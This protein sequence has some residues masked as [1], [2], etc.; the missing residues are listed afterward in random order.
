[1]TLRVG[2]LGAGAISDDHCR[3]VNAHPD[4]RIVAVADCSRK[5]RERIQSAYQ[6]DKG[7]A[8]WENLVADPDLDAVIVALPNYLHA[9]AAIRAFQKGKHVL[10]EKPFAMNW[11]EAKRI[12]AAA[13][14]AKRVLMLGMNRRF[15]REAQE[16]RT[17]VARGE[18]GEIYHAKTF[19]LRRQGAPKFNT[20]FVNKPLSGG[21]CML[22]IG[23]HALDLAMFLMN[24]W[25]PVCVS[26][27]TYGKFGHRGLG[28]GGWGQSD[29][30]SKL[31]FNVDDFSCALVKFRNGATLNVNISWA[32]HQA[33]KDEN[34]VELYG[35][36]AGARMSPLTL[37]RY[38]KRKGEMEDVALKNVKVPNFSPSR[39]A[40]WIETV[41]GRSKP[42]CEVSQSLVVQ[43]VLDGIYK[44][45]ATGREV[46]L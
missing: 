32:L 34:N 15:V 28:E 19:W 16:L 24:N 10:L 41:L 37:F 13:K 30:D 21:G 8:D 27:Q 33:E 3:G 29:R 36:E 40:H 2:L 22:D 6:V 43:R 39:Q 45:S 44:S 1:M 38:A 17:V 35:T 5:R 46:R 18:L 26:G 12:A 7:Y 14:R 11:G 25:E 42:I 31:K 9:P 4:A 20:W 23:V